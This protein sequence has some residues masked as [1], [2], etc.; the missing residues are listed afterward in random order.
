[1]I[2][3]PT[4]NG[5]QAYYWNHSQTTEPH[6]KERAK[7]PQKIQSQKPKEQKKQIHPKTLEDLRDELLLYLQKNIPSES[8]KESDSLKDQL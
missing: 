1:M 6:W 8:L 7:I 5:N 2:Q 4:Y 3:P